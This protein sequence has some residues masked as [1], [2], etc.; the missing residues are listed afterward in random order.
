MFVSK[1]SLDDVLH[2][3]L[4]K[5][6]SQ[7]VDVKPS[8]GHNKELLGVLI[9][10]TDPLARLSRTESR[11]RLFSCL[12]ETLWYFSN[13]SKLA[14]IE[15]YIPSYRKRA[16]IH[17]SYSFAP[18]GYGPRLFGGDDGVNQVARI[19]DNLSSTP[20]HNTRQAVVQ[21]FDKEDIGHPDVPCTC[22][23]QFLARGDRLHVI[24]YMRSNDAWIGLPH[25]IFAITW[26]QEVVARSIGHKVGTYKHMVGSLHVYQEDLQKI[27]EY[28]DEGHQDLR[29][30]P[31]MPLVDPWSSVAWL[32]ENE[33]RI[34]MGA[35]VIKSPDAVE[36]YW[37]DLA[38]ILLIGACAKE[39]ETKRILEERRKM[40]SDV[41]ESYVRR[42]EVASTESEQQPSIPGIDAQSTKR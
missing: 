19:I 15:H 37:Q 27:Q 26:L 28:L 25:D 7:G 41:Y 20:K 11:E 30:M 2:D 36:S 8:K 5:I 18:G 39:G 33:E 12:G 40:S 42:R 13:T 24:T 23:I 4:S 9:E 34:R 29:P 21:I 6:Q 17:A 10:L 35:R 3:V 16:G 1:A 22:L 38:R 32:L 31:A 14:Q